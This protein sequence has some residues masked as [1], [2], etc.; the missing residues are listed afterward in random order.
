MI[1]ATGGGNTFLGAFT[2]EYQQN[3]RDAVSAAN[4]A[5]VAASFAL[6]QVG[7]PSFDDKRWN[8]TTLAQRIEEYLSKM[9]PHIKAH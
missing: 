5:S 1:D 6:E 9:G 8:G 2:V 7:L 4:K 3:G